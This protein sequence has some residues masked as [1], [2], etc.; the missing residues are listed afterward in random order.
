MSF[1]QGYI[2][3]PTEHMLF[4]SKAF[5]FQETLWRRLIFRFGI[6]FFN[7]IISVSNKGQVELIFSGCSKLLTNKTIDVI[8][9]VK[10]FP[11]ALAKLHV[12]SVNTIKI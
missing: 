10:M 6:H 12:L 2:S 5:D 1:C 7:S 11:S 8:D 3:N 4:C 9:C